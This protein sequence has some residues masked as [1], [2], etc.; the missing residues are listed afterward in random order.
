M[1]TKVGGISTQPQLRVEL[2]TESTAA[3]STLMSLKMPLEFRASGT[4]ES[5]MAV[6]RAGQHVAG[7]QP[8]S[9][10]I[11]RRYALLLTLSS[12]TGEE[13]EEGEGEL[14]EAVR[15]LIGF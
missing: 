11:P 1:G 14:L 2:F 13:K 9:A 10:E 8:W 12:G 7:I 4:E 15:L 6:A 5:T 3:G